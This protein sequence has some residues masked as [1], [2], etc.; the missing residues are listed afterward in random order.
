MTTPRDIVDLALFDAGIA[1][2]GQTPTA[3]D[4]NKAFTRLNW[5]LSQW[6]RKR[7]L[8][9]H[10]ITLN[11]VSTGAQSYTVGPGGNIN[12]AVRPDRLESAFFRQ[13]IQSA[14][15]QIDYPLQILES[16]EDYNK[17]ALKQLATFPTYI[18]YDSAYPLGVIYPW[19][20]P[21]A[22]LYSVFITVKEVL[23]QFAN[24]SS[25]IVLP[26]EY[27]PALQQNLSVI[28]RAAYGLPPDPIMIGLAK[29]SLNTL[30]GANTQIG[31]LSM[32]ETLTRPGVYNPYSDQIR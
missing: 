7:W 24:L 23:T 32:P 31:R 16:R 28:L 30:R 18:F 4:E 5:M 8:V 12:T 14:P 26:E 17:I 19:P 27:F 2:V 13:T 20:I 9:Y 3:D 6:Q 25:T 15:N 1:G 10:L 21:Q 22:S 11:I 29:T